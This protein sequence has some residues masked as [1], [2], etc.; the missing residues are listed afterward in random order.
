MFLI[1]VFPRVIL[2]EMGRTSSTYGEKRGTYK[3]LVGKPEGWRQLGR[4]REDNIKIDLEKW[5]GSM[6]WTDLAHDRNKWRA[7][8]NMVINFRVR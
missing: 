4:P 7:L 6:N 2:H 3:V 5:D 8:V 1:F